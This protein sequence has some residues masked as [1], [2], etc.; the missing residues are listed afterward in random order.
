MRLSKEDLQ[1]LLL[2]IGPFVN[3][4]QQHRRLLPIGHSEEENHT[5]L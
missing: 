5:V 2:L 4:F 3:P 1:G